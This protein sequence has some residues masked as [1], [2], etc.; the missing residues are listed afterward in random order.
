MFEL[1]ETPNVLVEKYNVLTLAFNLK[2]KQR[3]Q[4]PSTLRHFFV[5]VITHRF[6][7][8]GMAAWT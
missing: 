4:N 6:M 5:V 8:Q 7:V 3:Y 1:G 2:E